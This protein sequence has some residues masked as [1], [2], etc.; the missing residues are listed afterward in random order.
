[1]SDLV[2]SQRPHLLLGSRNPLPLHD[3]WLSS[4]EATTWRQ[5]V[6]GIGMFT[7]DDGLPE[8]FHVKPASVQRVARHSIAAVFDATVA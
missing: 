4:V 1:M 3:T 7:D 5:L 8:V 6:A 2:T